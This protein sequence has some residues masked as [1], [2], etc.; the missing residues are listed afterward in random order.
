M[1][2]ASGDYWTAEVHGHCGGQAVITSFD[3]RSGGAG[4]LL[5]ALQDFG[6]RWRAVTSLLNVAYKC[7]AY[8]AQKHGACVVDAVGPT[9]TGRVH[10]VTTEQVVVP[11]NGTTDNGGKAGDALPPFVTAPFRKTT[12]D[13]FDR[14]N[15]PATIL[16]LPKSF[17]HLSPLTESDVGADGITLDVTAMGAL[18]TALRTLNSY[19]DGTPVTHTTR[20]V[21]RY[22]RR[23]SQPVAGTGASSLYWWSHGDFTIPVRVGSQLSRKQRGGYS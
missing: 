2:L 14:L 3:Y 15:D 6:S 13:F 23:V 21:S 4:P 16:S 8:V 12:Q 19:V 11:G 18:L 17:T 5:Q 10:Y 1:A 7:D 22:L 9:P 20:V